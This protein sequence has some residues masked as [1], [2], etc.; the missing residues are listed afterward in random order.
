M[1]MTRHHLH[2]A[3]NT[4]YDHCNIASFI[5]RNRFTIPYVKIGF[6]LF[7]ESILFLELS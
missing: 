4:D 6:S 3:I 7:I 5:L 2:T 1:M